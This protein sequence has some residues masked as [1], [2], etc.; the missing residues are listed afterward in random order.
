MQ[1]AVPSAL[2]WSLLAIPIVVFYIL[3]IRLRRVP[4]STVMFWNQIFDEK[5]PRSIW[6]R[7]RHLISLLL[8]LLFVI[9]LM[10][11]LTDPFFP[12]E[13]LQAKR[14]VLVVDNSASMNTTDESPTRLEAAKEYGRSLIRGLRLRD[15]MAIVSAGSVPRVEM[16]LTSHQKTLREALTTI[17]R[18]DGPTKV[19]EAV[20][21][22]RRL[23]ADHENANVIVLTDGGFEK[24]QEFAD[25]E[26]VQ[27]QTFGEATGNVA[28]T[29]FQVRRSL[30]DTIGYQILVEIQNFGDEDVEFR[31][32]V[33]LPNELVDVV[34]LKLKPDEKWARVLEHTSANGGE[35]I[36]AI[37][38]EDGLQCDN[39]AVALLPVRRPQP[40][41]LVSQGSLFLQSALQAIPLV[42]LSVSTEPP[43]TVPKNA[44]VVYHGITPEQVPAGNTMFIQPEKSTDL[45]KV[46]ESITDPIVTKQDSDSVLMTHVQLDNV[47][48]PE[49]KAIE[50]KRDHHALAQS[51]GGQPL[52]TALN[53][54]G[55]KALVLTVALEKGDLPLRT[56]FPIMITNAIAW[57][58]GRQGELQQA[59]AAGQVVSCDLSD[60]DLAA[61]DSSE[62]DSSDV[63]AENNDEEIG[64]VALGPVLVNPAGS[65]TSLPA[66]TKK[67]TV[68]PLDLCGIWKIQ[69]QS[70][71]NDELVD[72]NQEK[73]PQPGPLI[74]F[75][76]NLSNAQESDVRAKSFEHQQTQAGVF[77][78]R[79]IWFY[80]V[81]IGLLLTGTEWFLYQ[82][83]WIS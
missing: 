62:T 44:I 59:I 23:L 13:K 3:K 12:W 76:C 45:W 2:L 20:E 39:K 8:Q 57:F 43:K 35:L 15:Q 28:I 29:Q 79:P 14:I 1:L 73:Q 70:T 18:T 40:V 51:L 74:Q 41:L 32:E 50:F 9:L 24:A 67:L 65:E 42:D 10:F 60:S 71:A 38:V 75:A 63:P 47:L 61:T 54:P 58:Q 52:Y 22:A 66:G 80:L 55:G 6:Q 21:L 72:A 7:L 26:D 4:V 34:P 30:I 56:A 25:A 78:G 49:S 31:L 64:Q 11:A 82:R 68:G 77:G 27:L 36:A 33:N 5:K 19:T 37:N 53:H 17:R 48:M 81:V 46:G 16:G 83:R 69:N